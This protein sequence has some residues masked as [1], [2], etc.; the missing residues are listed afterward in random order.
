[1]YVWYCAYMANEQSNLQV[2]IPKDQHRAL[3]VH[4]A[5]TGTTVSDIVRELVTD[6]LAREKS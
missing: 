5:Q 2:T 4:A 1:M 6:F 3:R